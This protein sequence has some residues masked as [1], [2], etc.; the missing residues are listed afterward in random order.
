MPYLYS[1]ERYARSVA[2]IRELAADHDR[3]L[4]GF[5]W[6]A[7]VMVSVDVNRER[8][9]EHAARFLGTTYSQDFTEFIDRVS[10]A[11]P[12]EQVVE[13]LMAFVHAGA[14]HLVFLPCQDGASQAPG[15]W[16]TWLPE[17]LTQLR[18]ASAVTPP[19]G[20]AAPWSED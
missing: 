11:G 4:D 16:E 10:V 17:L 9:R 14:R 5:L 19:S 13:R 20:S 15:A 12:L 3:S 6:M 8:A 1:P 18:G 7:Y 2:T